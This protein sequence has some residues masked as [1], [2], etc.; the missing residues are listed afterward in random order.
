MTVSAAPAAVRIAW[1]V[2]APML[3]AMFR[4]PEGGQH[5]RQERP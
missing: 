1:A 4:A 5:E 3:R 2:L